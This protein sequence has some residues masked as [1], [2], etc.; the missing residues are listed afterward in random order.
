MAKQRNLSHYSFSPAEI[1]HPPSCPAKAPSP[2]R[3]EGRLSNL[4]QRNDARTICA[5]LG[6]LELPKGA[7]P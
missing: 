7:V 3:G 2:A 4:I 1:A 6:L 5:H